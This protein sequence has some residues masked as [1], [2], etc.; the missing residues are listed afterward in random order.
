[1]MNSKRINAVVNKMKDAGLDYLM[2]SEP[3]S[4][5]YLIDFVNNP[6]ER[7]Y[8]LMLGANGDHKL[9]FNKLFLSKR[10]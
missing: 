7:M 5:D 9:F 8:V 1:M 10:I 6:G 3:S 4:I 2:I